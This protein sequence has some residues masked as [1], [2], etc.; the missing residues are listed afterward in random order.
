[1]LVEDAEVRSLEIE[2]RKQAH[3]WRALH[4]R[5]TEREAAWKDKTQRLTQVVRQQQAQITELT[6]DILTCKTRRMT[7]SNATAHKYGRRNTDF[8]VMTLPDQAKS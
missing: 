3:Y 2:L 7:A 1:M 6:P 4:S 8:E 5:A